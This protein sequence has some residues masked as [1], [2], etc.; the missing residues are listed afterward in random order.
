MLAKSEVRINLYLDG[1]ISVFDRAL[2]RDS[3]GEKFDVN[4]IS[5]NWPLA[6]ELLI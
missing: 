6:W 2:L 1:D 3:L 4:R 5:C